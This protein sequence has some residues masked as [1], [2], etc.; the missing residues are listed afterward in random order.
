M[1]GA[2]PILRVEQL[3]KVFGSGRTQVLAVDHVDLTA[4]QGEV[5][6]IMGPSGSGKT[7]LL[8]MIG[9]LL[10]PT[11]GRIFI[12]G[13]EITA[14]RGHELPSVRRHHV[15]FVFQTF[16]LLDAL[17]AQENVEVALNVA[18]VSGAEARR[19]ARALLVEAG[20][21]GRLDFKA[22]DLSG[23][24]K[25]RVCIARALAN[26]PRLLLADEPTA[27][28]DTRHGHEVMQLLLD[29]T[30]RQGRT[31]IVVSHDL[32]L[33][34]IADRVLWLA[35]GRLRELAPGEG[36]PYRP[37]GTAAPGGR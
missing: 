6:L 4:G 37:A 12:D 27:N 1:S 28:L 26:E 2:R 35:D 36:G 10:R 13:L 16:N 17:T 23:G 15:G 14:M 24:E 5:V 25:Q 31:V 32:R 18:G 11:S 19:R 33:R 30:R 22:K 20:L 34:D 3:T 9:G 8:M 7:T 29:L 21:E